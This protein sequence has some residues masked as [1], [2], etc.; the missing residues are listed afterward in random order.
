M[1]LT[2]DTNTVLT[3]LVLAGILWLMRTVSSL[4][5]D[6]KADVVWK[7]MHQES[8]D[9]EFETVH[10]EIEEVREEQRRVAAA[11]AGSRR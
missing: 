11:L 10:D 2:L 1:S 3:S 4:S 9:K 6:S 5:S 8:D 7:K